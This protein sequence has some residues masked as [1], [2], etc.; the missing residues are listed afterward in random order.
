MLQTEPLGTKAQLG[1]A[2][3]RYCGKGHSTGA[4]YAGYV[5]NEIMPGVSGRLLQT[6]SDMIDETQSKLGGLNNELDWLQNENAKLNIAAITSP[7]ADVFVKLNEVGDKIKEIKTVVDQVKEKLN[8][9]KK[10][11]EELTDFQ[12]DKK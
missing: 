12:P 6:V 2:L 10:A 11:A 7:T 1:D 9:L 8:D 3:K 5:H 4:D